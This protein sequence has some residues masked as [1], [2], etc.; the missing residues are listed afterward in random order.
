[1]KFNDISK[2]FDEIFLS[3]PIFFVLLRHRLP[4]HSWAASGHIYMRKT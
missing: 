3:F 1:M 4:A 2:F